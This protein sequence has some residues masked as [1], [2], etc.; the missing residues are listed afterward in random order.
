MELFDAKHYELDYK[1]VPDK[2]FL[3]N[4]TIYSRFDLDLLIRFL[5]FLIN[6]ALI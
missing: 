2:G 4:F 1:T 6:V 5:R 3:F